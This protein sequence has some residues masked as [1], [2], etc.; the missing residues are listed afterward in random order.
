MASYNQR[1]PEN[2]SLLNL[3]PENDIQ[4][5]VLKYTYFEIEICLL[6]QSATNTTYLFIYLFFFLIRQLRK[7]T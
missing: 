2:L 3:V 4:E 5:D 1:A 6:L 7:A